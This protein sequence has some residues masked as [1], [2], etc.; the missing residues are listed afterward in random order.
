MHRARLPCA[1]LDLA[2][3]RVAG[4]LSRSH[5]RGAIVKR[6]LTLGAVTLVGTGV[7]AAVTGVRELPTALAAAD[8]ASDR[9]AELDAL[10][11]L[12]ESQRAAT[13]DLIARLADGSMS[14]AEVVDSLEENARG[15]PDFLG[16][17]A[18]YRDEPTDRERLAGFAR[19]RVRERLGDGHDSVPTHNNQEI[20]R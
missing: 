18:L 4:C 10:A 9:A 7:V 13:A 12:R 20:G 8:A 15:R 5:T 2:N 3:R 11:R 6:F 19:D 17:L 1:I 14:L 16:H